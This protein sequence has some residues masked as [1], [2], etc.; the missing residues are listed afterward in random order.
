MNFV[1]VDSF[2]IDKFKRRIVKILRLGKN[3]IQTGFEALPAQVDS[4]PLK[5]MDAIYAPTGERG[6]VAIIGYLNKNQKAEAG[7]FRAYSLDSNG[8]EK[9]YVWLKKNG[10]IELGGTDDNAVRYSPLNDG[11]QNFK[12]LLTAELIK[13]QAG[14]AAGGGSYSPGTLTVDISQA[15]INEI[16]TL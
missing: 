11:L 1:K 7:E 16:K 10:T 9:I 4:A 14:I 13:I 12:D 5:N 2:S 15:K 3:D 8:G 6:K